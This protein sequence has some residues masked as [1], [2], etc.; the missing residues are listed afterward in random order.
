[1]HHVITHTEEAVANREFILGAFPDIEGAFDSTTFDIITKAVKWH[2]LGDTICRWISSRLGSRKIT[3]TLAGENLERS[4]ARGCPQGSI[5]LPCLWNL[6]VDELIGGLNGNGYY[7]LG[8]TDDTVIL[9]CPKFL[10]T[11][12]ELLQEAL[13]MVQQWCDRTQMSNNPKKTV[14]VSFAHKRDFRG[15]KEPTLTGHTLQL[16]TKVKYL[17]L[18]LD[19]GLTGKAQLINA[20][21]HAYR[22]FWSCKG[23]FGKK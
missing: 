9:I 2:G 21:N 11:A 12:S 23:I 6:V 16:T 15:L 8:Q 18:I 22:A 20:M 17:G 7:T 5:L 1:M 14:I 13:S 4:V 19:K 10:N 3:A